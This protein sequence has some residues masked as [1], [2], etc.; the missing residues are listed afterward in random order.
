MEDPFAAI[1]GT[2]KWFITLG[3]TTLVIYWVAYSFW[4]RTLPQLIIA[5]S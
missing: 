4:V 3:V 2:I 5:E 1:K